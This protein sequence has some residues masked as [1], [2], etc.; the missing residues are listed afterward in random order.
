M[1]KR[2]WTAAV[3]AAAT[4]IWTGFC[5]FLSWQ[6]GEGTGRL[7]LTL[8]RWLMRGLA[9]VGLHPEET[10]F[11]MVLR[12]FA[13]FG[14]F[15]IS[16]ALLCGTVEAVLRLKP[17]GGWIRVCA[18]ILATAT[19]LFADVPKVWIPGRHLTWSESWL[20]AAGAL[21]GYL[22]M[23]ALTAGVDTRK[24]RGAPEVRKNGKK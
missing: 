9:L 13:H 18:A 20:N 24:K 1:R 15:F 14:V 3:W 17:L 23:L 2:I 21:A 19:A 6:T 10:A 16:G 11:H 5:L 22:L 4:V 8:T 7:S 12:E